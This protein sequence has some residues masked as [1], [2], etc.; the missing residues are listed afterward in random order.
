MFAESDFL[1]FITD[2]RAETF[3]LALDEKFSVVRTAANH[4]EI[5]EVV[6]QERCDVLR[7]FVG[8]G[9]YYTPNERGAHPNNVQVA[10]EHL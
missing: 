6:G 8:Q 5:L 4:P 1:A 2:R 10:S 3:K 9:A 7:A